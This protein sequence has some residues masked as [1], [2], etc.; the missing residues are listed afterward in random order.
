MAVGP[1]SQVW[2]IYMFAAMVGAIHF[3]TSE[4]EEITTQTWVFLTTVRKMR[5]K[6]NGLLAQERLLEV[7][8]AEAAVVGEAPV[9]VEEEEGGVD[10]TFLLL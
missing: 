4:E 5:A 1:G 10:R 6:R 2:A 3:P 8:Q 7:H 9:G